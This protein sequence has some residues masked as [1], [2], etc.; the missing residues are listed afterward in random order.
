MKCFEIRQNPVESSIEVRHNVINTQV[1]NL[2]IYTRSTAVARVLYLSR[3][4]CADDSPHYCLD[5]CIFGP[6]HCP[7][8]YSA[9]GGGIQSYSTHH[10]KAQTMHRTCHLLGLCIGWCLG[11]QDHIIRCR[12]LWSSRPPSSDP[13]QLKISM[14][15]G[16]RVN[17]CLL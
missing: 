12:G 14:G 16:A 6:N 1:C 2:R 5:R 9:L 4:V 7:C 17:T 10:V 11:G 8:M 15:P 13:G 3:W